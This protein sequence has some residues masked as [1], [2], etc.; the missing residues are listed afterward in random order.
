MRPLTRRSMFSSVVLSEIRR[1]HLVSKWLMQ[2][3][4]TYQSKLTNGEILNTLFAL[5]FTMRIILGHS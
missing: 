2:Y 4:V 5:N 3:P 1:F